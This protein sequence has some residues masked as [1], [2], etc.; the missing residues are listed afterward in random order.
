LGL[1][2]L[3]VFTGDLEDG[4]FKGSK[5]KHLESCGITVGDKRLTV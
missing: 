5:T 4:T 1:P 2:V 3:G